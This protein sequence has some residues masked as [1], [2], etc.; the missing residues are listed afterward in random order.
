VLQQRY[1]GLLETLHEGYR[2]G[3]PAGAPAINTARTAMLGAGGMEGAL[4]AV[5]AQGFLAVF[6]QI[7]D[8]PRFAPVD[9]PSL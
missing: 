2:R 7:G 8:D 6:E 4:E 9:P 5:A 1:R 3:I